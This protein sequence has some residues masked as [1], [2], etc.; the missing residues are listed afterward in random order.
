MDGEHN[1]RLT[2][3]AVEKLHFGQNTYAPWMTLRLHPT[4]A[5]EVH[6]ITSPDY[7]VWSRRAS[8]RYRF[9]D[10]PPEVGEAPIIDGPVGSG[11]FSFSRVPGKLFAAKTMLVEYKDNTAGMRTLTFDISGLHR[12]VEG[13]CSDLR[14]TLDCTSKAKNI[15]AYLDAAPIDR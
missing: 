12:K 11:G 1:I 2:R 5:L 13:A 14:P 8:I 15:Q 3:E 9:D 10:Q 7:N 4:F 6:T